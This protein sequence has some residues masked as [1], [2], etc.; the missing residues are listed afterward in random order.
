MN[1]SRVLLLLT[2]VMGD[3][4]AIAQRTH[5]RQIPSDLEFVTGKQAPT[6]TRSHAH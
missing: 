2:S 1:P 3:R 5:R 6:C 4:R